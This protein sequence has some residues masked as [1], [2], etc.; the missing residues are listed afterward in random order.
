MSNTTPQ[1]TGDRF[2]TLNYWCMKGFNRYKMTPS[3]RLVWLVLWR[4]AT[5]SGKV[6][7]AFSRIALETGYTVRSCKRIIASLKKKRIIVLHKRGNA[8][9]RVNEYYIKVLSRKPSHCASD[10][11]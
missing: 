6:T 2:Y 3:E 5:R 11:K 7:L 10:K 9:G 8:L 1:E 4:S